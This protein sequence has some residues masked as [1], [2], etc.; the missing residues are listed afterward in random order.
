MI[1]NVTPQRVGGILLVIMV[2][3]SIALTG[4]AA[5]SGLSPSD[6]VENMTDT[7]VKEIAAIGTALLSLFGLFQIVQMGISSGDSSSRLRKAGLSFGLAIL[8]QSWSRIDDWI[9][10]INASEGAAVIDPTVVDGV[11]TTIA[12][13]PL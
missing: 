3:G 2:V 1:D 5:A 12:A 7:V 4:S 13:L 10:G 11:V 8:L 9:S 6:A